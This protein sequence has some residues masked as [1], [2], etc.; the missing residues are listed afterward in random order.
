M[1][2]TQST[3]TAETARQRKAFTLIELLVVIAIISI[4]AA[5]LFPVFARAR[6]NARR[7][8]C[9]SN[10]KQIGLGFLQY[11]QDND[12][13]FPPNKLETAWPGGAIQPYLKSM[14]ILRCPNDAGA[15]WQAPEVTTTSYVLNGFF[16]AS[17]PSA[18]PST[19][20][21]NQPELGIKSSHIVS[22]QSPASVIMLA[23]APDLWSG[24]YFHAF[25]WPVPA[26]GSFG[27]YAGNWKW[28]AGERDP[29]PENPYYPNYPGDLETVRHLGGFNAGFMDGHAKW[30]KWERAYKIDYSVNPPI[31][32]NFDPRASE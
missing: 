27:G 7:T 20:P 31:K 12:E 28:K 21:W 8:S 2:N 22:I 4:L 15:K 3:P 19:N 16:P 32:G 18:T 6:E 10:Q 1:P 9:L 25:A 29:D 24:S 11:F 23:E 13:Q 17:A 14:Q 30:V 26:G 5:I